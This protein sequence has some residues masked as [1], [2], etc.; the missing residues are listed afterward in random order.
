MPLQY[1]VYSG[2]LRPW[3]RYLENLTGVT[4]QVYA[5]NIKCSSYNSEMLL[6]A[7]QYAVAYVKAVGQEASLHQVYAS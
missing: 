2:T 5:G 1:G 3:C 7:A 6:S 4:P